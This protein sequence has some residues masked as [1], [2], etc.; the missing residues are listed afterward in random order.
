MLFV[1]TTFAQISGLFIVGNSPQPSRGCWMRID[2]K[3][4]CAESSVAENAAVAP[5]FGVATGIL[6]FR[7]RCCLQRMRSVQAT[8]VACPCYDLLFWQTNGT[9]TSVQHTHTQRHTWWPPSSLLSAHGI[10]PRVQ[11]LENNVV[12]VP[13]G[14]HMR[15]YRAGRTLIHLY[16][17]LF[18]TTQFCCCTLCKSRNL[19]CS[20][21]DNTLS[22]AGP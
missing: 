8:G 20:S 11:I 12:D 17:T 21:V 6:N 1:L 9:P 10:K 7:A 14:G 2:A 15:K 18:F 3:R 19:F 5:A 22:I 4:G 16:C 13:E